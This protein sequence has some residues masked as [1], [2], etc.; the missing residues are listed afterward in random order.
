M[1][2]G[3]RISGRYKVK[4][5]IGGGGMA[6]VY[7][8]RD[9]ILDRDVAVKVLRLD[10]A[11]EP[12][13]IQRFHREAQSA[14]S[15][16][17]PNIVSIYDIGEEDDLNYIVMENVDGMTLK[18]YIQQNGPVSV[19]K[20]LDIMGQL[21][22]A[23]S[24]AHQNHII[25]RDIKPQN[26]LISHDGVV[27]IT[28][29]GIAMALSATS[30]TQTNA[31]L[32]SVHYLSPEQAR[33]GMATYKSDIYALGIVMFEL[34]TGRLPF[35]GESA[36]SIALKH[37]QSETP[38]PKR[39]NPDIPQSVENIVLKATAKDPFYRY[40]SAD[41]MGEDI[42]TAL[43]PERLDE[44]KFE[45]P[46]DDEQTKI[47]PVFSETAAGPGL[48]DETIVVN[49]AD[50]NEEEKKESKRDRKEKKRR[51]WPVVL[52]ILFFF[53]VLAGLAALFLPSFLGPKTVSVPDVA[54]KSADAAAAVLAE[55]GLKIG[56]K[57]KE[58]SETV[59]KGQIIKTDPGAGEKIKEGSEVSLYISAGKEKFS[60]SDY[61]GR[62]F[63]DVVKLLSGEH[64]KDIKKEEVY[65]DSIA[66]TILSQDPAPDK[67]IVPE[68]TIITFT[69]S[70]GPE[71]VTVQDL[72]GLSKSQLDQYEKESG[73]SIEILGKEY[74][75]TVK[76]NHVI[77][78]SPAAGTELE[79]GATIKVTFSK[80]PKELPPKTVTKEVTIPYEPYNSSSEKTD[81]GSYNSGG[82]TSGQGSQP[83]GHTGDATDNTTTGTTNST[84]ADQEKTKQEVQIYIED[85]NH[86]M[87]EPAETF[88]I[89]KTVKKQLEFTIEYGKEA[90]YKIVRN[91]TVI[92]E[93]T[94]PYP[95]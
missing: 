88:E 45:I 11:N 8:A 28:D 37:L 93:E 27:K 18:Q 4:S 9:M 41:E 74:S 49:P 83:D 75:D 90:T 89:T 48:N 50:E 3:R 15:L 10:C 33:G 64:F 6:N 76:K 31:V 66:G 78:Q 81:G 26:I 54:G 73:F 43:N 82:T 79:K 13:F 40:N 71:T 65:D 51:K 60:L 94:V 56:E 14:T 1:L 86:T 69:V 24:H 61:T 59:P 25:H 23:I 85:M 38:S 91:G 53:L 17:H 47:M 19:E 30:I 36:V 2:I 77:S 42:R 52:G 7:L 72:T 57:L 84:T 58:T 62:Q 92:T 32:G 29:F 63:N 68:D 22:A 34:L 67:K 80:G 16:V 39:W 55:H 87:S 5:L 12:E 44:P 95:K 46:D 20:T 35:S 21:T 70:K